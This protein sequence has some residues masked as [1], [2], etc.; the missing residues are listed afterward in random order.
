MVNFTNAAL[1]HNCLM[2]DIL[3]DIYGW[4]DRDLI[5][6]GTGFRNDCYW[7]KDINGRDNG[8]LKVGWKGRS[9]PHWHPIDGEQFDAIRKSHLSE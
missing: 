2:E 3:P 5:S 7:G 6:L 9:C 1:L 4:C 8:C